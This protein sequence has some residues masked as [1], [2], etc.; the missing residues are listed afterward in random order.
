MWAPTSGRGSTGLHQAGGQLARGTGF[1]ARFLVSVP[2]S[3]QGTREYR[4]PGAMPHLET[5]RRR[6]AALLS[7]PAPIQED[8][9]LKPATAHLDP[10]AKRGWIGFHDAI[11][12]ELG[13]GGE[14][15][16][17]RDVASKAAEN[18]ARLAALFQAYATDPT[19]DGLEV[20]AESFDRAGR[21]VAWHL[22]E[23]RRFFGELALPADLADAARLEAWLIH[24][25]QSEHCQ[26]VQRN[27]ARQAGPRAVRDRQRL[28]AALKVLVDLDRV[29]L[30]PTRPALID[31]NPVLIGGRL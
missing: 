26:S 17:V 11:E 18:A 4:E 30:T 16:E 23:S 19:A 25:C 27:R 22:S 2:Q 6:L 13:E 8:G 15:R 29:R 28:E 1:F 5:Y 24:V 21:I 3:T 12:R 9:T 14:L 10:D 20:T 31:V 7:R